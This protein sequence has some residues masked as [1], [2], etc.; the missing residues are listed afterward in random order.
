[1][2]N[3]DENEVLRDVLSGLKEEVPPM[4]EDLHAAWM[5]K[6]E[7]DMQT[8]EQRAPR[9]RQWTRFLSVAAALVF[10]VGGTLLTR[11]DLAG[12]GQEKAA[13]Q[14][15]NAKGSRSA[16]VYE[17]MA[18]EESAADY[19]SY[20]MVAATGAAPMLA[21]MTAENGAPAAEAKI[22]RTASVTIA[23]PDYDTSL[24]T[25]KD[26]CVALGGWISWAKESIAN[27]TGLRSANLTLRV[28]QTALDEYLTGAET[29]GRVTYRSETATDVTV[30][31]QDTAARLATQQALMARLQSLITESA[32]L[33]DLLA[34][35]SQMAETQYQIDRL[36][37]SLNE[38]DSEVTYATAD[39]T[40]REELTPGLTEEGVSFLDRVKAGIR[41]GWETFA[42]FVSDM[43]VF[44]V[45]ALPFLLVAGVA[46]MALWLAL[47][48]KRRK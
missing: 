16:V 41:L 6:V 27:N 44:L 34:L 43:A 46:W 32:S 30:S 5:Q 13:P 23:T 2:Y 15:V 21:K 29:L 39:V 22:I 3:H 24:T 36:Q 48:V 18:E 38:T 25:L 1:M 7:D 8:P 14:A 42:D 12:L 20:D 17:D 33:S 35:E 31:Y 4:P 28:P 9:Y 19:G 45:A 47:R 40:L 26:R 10:V 37:S 11:D